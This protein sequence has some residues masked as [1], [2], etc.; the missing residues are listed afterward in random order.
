MHTRIHHQLDNK[1]V[2]FGKNLK[3]AKLDLLFYPRQE[4]NMA[5]GYGVVLRWQGP[6]ETCHHFDLKR[7]REHEA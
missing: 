6:H 3:I 1:L 5:N 4:N 2:L 7:V